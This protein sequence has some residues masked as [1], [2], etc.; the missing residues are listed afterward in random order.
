MADETLDAT[1]P[2]AGAP[3]GDA[4]TEVTPPAEPGEWDDPEPLAEGVTQFD[5]PYVE[6][7]RDREAKY[8]IKARELH[9][10]VD[11]FGGSEKIEQ[12][13]QFFDRGQTEEG[14]T[15]LFIEAGQA[16]GL[17][18]KELEALF[19]ANDAATTA[20]AKAAAAAG[21]ADDDV[22][23]FAEARALIEKEV[24]APQ[25]EAQ[26][27]RMVE[28]A[29]ATVADAL[30]DVPASEHA[31]VLALGQPHLADGDFDPTHVR[32]AI[33]KGIE[34]LENAKTADREEYLKQKLAEQVATPGSTAG[35]GAAGAEGTPPPAN[36]EEA[37]KRAR[38]RLAAAAAAAA[39]AAAR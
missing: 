19:D 25:R 26:E 24:L 16:L 4:T 27:Q 31:A 7:L 17:G 2:E 14:V 10:S 15:Q 13:V 11:K 21:P 38:T 29:R 30:K 33:R 39:E 23:T 36:W 18:F 20:A 9:E 6:K 34:L 37:K 35:S 12:A 22:M 8:R 1:S 3:A 5:R 32:M 28:V